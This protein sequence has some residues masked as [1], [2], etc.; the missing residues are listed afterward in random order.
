MGVPIGRSPIVIPGTG[1]MQLRCRCGHMDFGG[2][3]QPLS[4]GG[5]VLKELVCRQCAFVL[6]V[7]PAD[8]SFERAGQATDMEGNRL[9]GG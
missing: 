5:A 2:H 8:M 9:N 4:A 7:R 3:V 6:K 1:Q